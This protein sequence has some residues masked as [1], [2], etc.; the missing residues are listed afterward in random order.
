VTEHSRGYTTVELMVAMSI[1]FVVVGFA[2]SAYFFSSRMVKTWRAK[3]E[4]EDTAFVCMDRISRDVR[5]CV[6]VRADGGSGA[7]LILEHGKAIRYDLKNGG[8][9][10]NGFQMNQAAMHVDTLL[11]RPIQR[12]GDPVPGFSTSGASAGTAETSGAMQIELIVYN[13]VKRM[14]LQSAVFPRNFTQSDFY[15]NE[16]VSVT[17]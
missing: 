1:A 3:T 7:F 15:K 14:R 8:L 11:F 6:D 13:K 5:R 17:D 16:G 12:A 10:R 2:Y 4:C 9:F